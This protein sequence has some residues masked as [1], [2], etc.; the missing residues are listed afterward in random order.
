MT[1]FEEGRSIELFGT[2]GYLKGGYFLRQKTGDDIHVNLFNGEQQKY[3]IDVDEEDH[4]MGGDDGIMDALYEEMGGEN[5][6]PVS[7]YIQSHIMG[8]AAEKSRV[9]GQTVHLGA[10]RESFRK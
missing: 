10:Y 9:T 1:A 7:S 8:Y 6:V 3:R 2:K 4:H 5:S